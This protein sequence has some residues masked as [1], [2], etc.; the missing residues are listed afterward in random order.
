MNF[1]HCS[2]RLQQN[3]TEKSEGSES[4]LNALYLLKIISDQVTTFTTAQLMDYN[5]IEQ[6]NMLIYDK[7]TYR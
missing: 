1:N 4:F 5:K 7:L 3:K 6:N 2:V